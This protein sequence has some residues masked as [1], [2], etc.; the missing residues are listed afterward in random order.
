MASLVDI[1]DDKKSKPIKLNNLQIDLQAKNE[2]K[3]NNIKILK[4]SPCGSS[5]PILEEQAMKISYDGASEQ[6]SEEPITIMIDKEPFAKGAMRAAY[7]MTMVGEDGSLSNWVA[8]S[9]INAPEDP[10]KVYRNDVIVQMISR[11]YGQLYDAEDTPKKVDMIPA[12]MIRMINRPNKDLY[13]IEPQIDGEYIKYNTNGGFIDSVHWHNTPHAF[14]HFTFE[15]SGRTLM[16]VDIQGVG[17]VYTDP[18]IHTSE[19]KN[20]KQFGSGNLGIKGIA[21]FLYTHRCNPICKHLNLPEFSLFEDSFSEAPAPHLWR[22]T[23]VVGNLFANMKKTL[24]IPGQRP[25]PP[26]LR[27]NPDSAK[28]A[29]QAV[30]QPLRIPPDFQIPK[31]PDTIAWIHYE[32]GKLHQIG[33]LKEIDKKN[34]ELLLERD[35]VKKGLDSGEWVSPDVPAAFFHFQKAALGGCPEAMLAVARIHS[36]N[37][38]VLVGSDVSMLYDPKRVFRFLKMA[39]DR[40]SRDAIYWVGQYYEMGTSTIINWKNAQHYYSLLL[41]SDCET[42][43]D[44]YGWEAPTFM[45]FE[46]KA[47]LAK[48][49]STGGNELEEDRG[50]AYELYS[51]AAEEAMM[52]RKGKEAMHYY[53]V[54]ESLA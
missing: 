15:K 42:Y 38:D 31:Q 46:I 39:A 6:W 28:L 33:K 35:P 47:V 49:L 44:L 48:L 11:Y 19:R 41:N 25:S 9:Y 12:H 7:R 23:S 24:S 50:T 13:C 16:I 21:L 43:D 1:F 52:L 17:D 3:K 20:I 8:K 45:K 30:P 14:S 18:Q 32:I 36:K 51:E 4:V 10:E 54:M 37:Q 5:E 2:E 29:S 27:H 34:Y 22:G 53:Q 40:G 26:T